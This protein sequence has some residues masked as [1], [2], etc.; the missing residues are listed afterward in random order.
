M[1]CKRTQERIFNSKKNTSIR[2]EINVFRRN[3]KDHKGV[4][5][6][7]CYNFWDNLWLSYFLQLYTTLHFST[8]LILP[9]P[10]QI[11][12]HIWPISNFSNLIKVLVFFLAERRVSWGKLVFVIGRSESLASLFSWLIRARQ[13]ICYLSPRYWGS[14]RTEVKANTDLRCSALT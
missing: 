10:I 9:S 3:H 1:I 13:L 8:L 6:D 7:I 2:S 14:G 5:A 11:N 12:P 4:L